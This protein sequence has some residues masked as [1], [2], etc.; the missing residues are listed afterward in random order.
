MNL[1]IM[2]N[3]LQFNYLASH[4]CSVTSANQI[5]V[6]LFARREQVVQNPQSSLLIRESH[7]IQHSRIFSVNEGFD[8]S[9]EKLCIFEAD[10]TQEY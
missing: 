10:K 7:I 4:A 8:S 5:C 6:S 3:V 2:K 9:N 1:L